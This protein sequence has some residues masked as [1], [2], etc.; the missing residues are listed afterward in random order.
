MFNSIVESKTGCP[1]E[2]TL[3]KGNCY[4]WFTWLQTDYDKA[5]RMCHSAGARVLTIDSETEQ[6]FVTNHFSHIANN[7]WF[8]FEESKFENWLEDS[9]AEGDC[10]VVHFLSRDVAK[11]VKEDCFY[12]NDVVCKTA[13][14]KVQESICDLVKEIDVNFCDGTTPG[15]T[16]APTKVPT[17]D[18]TRDPTWAPTIKPTQNPT[19][20][21]PTRAP[22]HSTTRDPTRAPTPDPTRA[23]TSTDSPTTVEYCQDGWH[24]FIYRCFKLFDVEVNQ[25][26]AERRCRDEKS[27]LVSIHTEGE[28]RFLTDLGVKTGLKRAWIGAKIVRPH[29]FV[30]QWT[31]G[32]ATNYQHLSHDLVWNPRHDGV[33]ISLNQDGKEAGFWYNEDPA[34]TKD[35]GYICVKGMSH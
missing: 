27:H 6:Q 34:A 11:W 1:E 4:K 30:F 2:W 3:Y 18:P 24:P 35:T 29:P 23:P 25:T 5:E 12:H 26:E 16:L 33:L 20:Q 31:D 32:T 7:L 13:E 14:V 10:A 21:V 15:P 22:I 28:N 17:W 8:N 9:G 19:T